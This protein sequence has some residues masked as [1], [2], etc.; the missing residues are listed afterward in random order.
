MPEHVHRLTYRLVR[1]FGRWAVSMWHRVDWDVQ[2][3]ERLDR[4]SRGVTPAR[5]LF[6]GHQNGLADPVLACVT[7]SPQ[8]HFF[9]RSDVF[10][11]KAARWFILRLN[12]M[13]IFRPIDRAPNMAER[14][15]A[16]FEA[17]QTRLEKGATCGIFPEA[18]HLDERRIRRFRHGSARF[19]AGALQRPEVRRRGLEIIPMHMDFERYSGYRTGARLTLGPPVEHADIEGL[20]DDTGGARIILSERM[21]SALISTGVHLEEGAVYDAHL[22]VLRFL[23]GHAA[24]R[25]DPSGIRAVGVE[26]LRHEEEVLADFEGALAAGI[27]HPRSHD[28]FAAAGRLAAGRATRLLPMA[29]RFP[30]WL[31]FIST[32]GWWPPIIAAEAERR[33]KSMAFRTTFSI[34]AHMVA[35]MLTWTV[36]AAAV[37]LVM[38][39]AALFPA[40]LLG[41]RACQWC[42]LPFEDARID[43]RLER[44]TGEFMALPF[45]RKWCSPALD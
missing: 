12:M 19:I 33:V 20:E 28:H 26:L 35:V 34:P 6:G 18:G 21:R 40:G 4:S 27:G 41:L 36:L 10:R 2:G 29:W 5:L 22:A 7:L 30:A 15:K 17:A 32:T 14:N 8:L 24:G 39:H 3:A 37:S 43:R 45:I 9:T 42:G 23:E 44:Q 11:K 31:V 13:P 16:T 1:P 38:G 25:V